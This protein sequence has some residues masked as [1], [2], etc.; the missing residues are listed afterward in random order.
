MGQI[1][2]LIRW[3]FTHD[4]TVRVSG[5]PKFCMLARVVWFIGSAVGV[6]PR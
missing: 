6:D 4:A 3:D 2:F 5:R 1:S